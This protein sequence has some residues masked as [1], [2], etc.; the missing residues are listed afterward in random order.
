MVRTCRPAESPASL[1]VDH[2]MSLVHLRRPIVDQD[3]LVLTKPIPT[4]GA[5]SS[6]A[7]T[8]LA[9]EVL[10]LE[11]SCSHPRDGMSRACANLADL[12]QAATETSDSSAACQI[13]DVQKPP[14]GFRR[15]C[16][17]IS[18]SSN[19][20]VFL[21]LCP[22]CG[23]LGTHLKGLSRFTPVNYYGCDNCQ[24]VWPVPKDETKP[25][26]DAPWSSSSYQIGR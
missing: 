1:V 6:A 26:A 5:P 11:L 24:H 9:E 3:R 15:Y 4:G 10:A 21:S 22:K 23:Q 2:V 13:L 18:C 17:A 20:R 12:A 7:A 16:C 14:D 19:M 8:V 25:T